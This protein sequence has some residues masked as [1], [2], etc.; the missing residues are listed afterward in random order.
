MTSFTSLNISA[1]SCFCISSVIGK[2]VSFW[3]LLSEKLYS[4]SDPV[5]SSKRLFQV[6]KN[7]ILVGEAKATITNEISNEITYNIVIRNGKQIFKYDEEGLSPISKKFDNPQEIY[8]LSFKLYDSKG[9]EVN[10]DTLEASS[11]SWIVP[12][13]DSMI[14]ILD[15]EGEPSEI[16]T[17]NHNDIYTGKKI[18]FFRIASIY[19]YKKTRN[20]IEIRVNYNNKIISAT[21]DFIF[22]KEG[23][24][25]S[26]G[27]DYI[28]RVV[29]NNKNTN[30][31]LNYPIVYHNNASGEIK[32]NYDRPIGEENT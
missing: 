7:D 9:V 31:K 19:D 26:N 30:S 22:L 25:G 14:E 29:L 21:T 18:L 16:D 24:N 32:L 23:E 4:P 2:A 6:Y 28:C 20:S 1:P 13:Q 8:P 11:Y 27:T 15:S 10:L 3:I 5:V 17:E 12:N